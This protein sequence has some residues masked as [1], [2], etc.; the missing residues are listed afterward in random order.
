MHAL[1]KEFFSQGR[2]EGV[3]SLF[4]FFSTL[5]L[6]ILAA[7]AGQGMWEEHG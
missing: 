6:T 5:L 4:Y 7:F 2:F 1:R 3:F